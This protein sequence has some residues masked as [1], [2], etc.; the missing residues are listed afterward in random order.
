MGMM[1]ARKRC[2]LGLVCV[3][4][5]VVAGMGQDGYTWQETPGL[6]LVKPQAWSKESQA[7]VLEFEALLDR[8]ATGSRGAGYI[9]FRIS[10]DQTRQV[11]LSR[12]FKVVI[13]PDAGRIVELVTQEDRERVRG[14]VAEIEDVMERFPTTKRYLESRLRVFEQDIGRFDAGEVKVKGTW[15]PQSAYRQVQAGR[16]TEIL[17]AELDSAPDGVVLDI[18]SDPRYQE[19]V[20]MGSTVPA[21]QKMARDIRD[22]YAV[23]ERTRE[24][25]EILGELEDPSRPIGRCR[26]LVARLRELEPE[27]DMEAASILEKW[28]N[29]DTEAVALAKVA[30]ELTAPMEEALSGIEDYAVAP[31]I[32]SEVAEPV[33]SLARRMA[34]LRAMNPPPQVLGE[35]GDAEALIAVASA[36]AGLQTQLPENDFFAAKEALDAAAGGAP[37]IGP[38]AVSAVEGYQKLVTGRIEVFTKAREEARAHEEAGRTAEALAKYKEAYAAVAE[39]AIG[40][41]IAALEGGAEAPAPSQ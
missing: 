5:G 30:G 7:R 32:P 14:V 36:M 31:Q 13:Y 22:A 41:R 21:A 27:E 4:S 40:E 2:V 26:E 15:I 29:S 18:E 16:L 39:A 23:R 24:R 37:S 20:A 9:E 12:L 8:R 28:E 33:A 19:L 17:K 25:A 6:A 34:S 38:G 3:M 11:D 35:T 10:G 1:F